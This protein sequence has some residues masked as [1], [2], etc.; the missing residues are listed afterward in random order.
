MEQLDIPKKLNWQ[1]LLLK[2]QTIKNPIL[3]I[4][5]ILDKYRYK[6]N[7]NFLTFYNM[8]DFVFIKGIMLFLFGILLPKQYTKM[9]K[10]TNYFGAFAKFAIPKNLPSYVIAFPENP[11]NYIIVFPKNP[12]R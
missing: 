12:F 4:A 10:K 6:F 9:F 5:E 7:P 11:Y 1:F 3:L 2:K 8:D